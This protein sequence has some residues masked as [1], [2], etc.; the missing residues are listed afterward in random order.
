[1]TLT[2]KN[3]NVLSSVDLLSEAAVFVLFFSLSLRECGNPSVNSHPRRERSVHVTGI[4]VK[5]LL[6]S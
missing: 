4:L 2:W 1:M 3:L 6:P 5:M